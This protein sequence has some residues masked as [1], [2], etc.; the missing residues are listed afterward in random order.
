[1]AITL[2]FSNT[3]YQRARQTVVMSLHFYT[4]F[5]AWSY[6]ILSAAVEG[7]TSCTLPSN[8]LPPSSS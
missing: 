2:V 6:I 5:Q 8:L 7:V 1:M 4:A 3:E